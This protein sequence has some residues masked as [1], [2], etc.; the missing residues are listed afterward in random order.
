MARQRDPLYLPI[1]ETFEVSI[2]LSVASLEKRFYSTDKYNGTIRFYSRLLVDICPASVVLDLGA[3]P[4]PQRG[5]GTLKGRVAKLVGADIDDAVLS[6][7][8]MD[9]AV[10]IEARNPLPFPSATFDLVYSD[11][12]VEHVENP[13][14]FLSEVYRVLKPGGCFHFRTPNIYHYVTLISRITPHRFHILVAN[15]ARRLSSEAHDPWPTFYRLNSRRSIKRAARSVGFSDIGL[16]MIEC[17]PDYL[18]FHPLPYLMGT[19]YERTINL[20]DATAG[21]RANILGRLVKPR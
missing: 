14:E 1:L 12:V 6:N 3:G 15:A 17:S 8:G 5:I 20:T 21:M 4:K 9:E 18:R 19:L 16:E 11:Y 2:V 10:K 13:K 7:P